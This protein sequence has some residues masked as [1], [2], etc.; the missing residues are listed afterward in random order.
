M[1]LWW[2]REFGWFY[3]EG[4]VMKRIEMEMK[5]VMVW[6]DGEFVFGDFDEDFCC[7]VDIWNRVV[8]ICGEG[9]VGRG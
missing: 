3:L 5:L 7:L 2:D 6:S 8:V 9:F 4:L 1:C